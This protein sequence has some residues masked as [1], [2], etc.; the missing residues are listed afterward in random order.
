MSIEKERQVITP[1]EMHAL[2]KAARD[3]THCIKPEMIHPVKEDDRGVV[4]EGERRHEVFI[5]YHGDTNSEINEKS[6]RI[7]KYLIAVNPGVVQRLVDEI[8]R[9]APFEKH[10]ET[11]KANHDN[12][13]SRARILM[14]RPDMPVERVKA[15]NRMYE[16]E[17]ENESLKRRIAQLSDSASVHVKLD[18]LFHEGR[19]D[20]VIM[21]RQIEEV[22]RIL[23]S[24]FRQQ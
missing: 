16:L 23:S 10:A 20:R 17:N 3:M 18:T 19:A 24:V 11:W 2:K 9:L 15:Y 7:A 5:Q 1:D 13:V 14:E 21:G 4:L 12:Q 8:E 6:E 22:H